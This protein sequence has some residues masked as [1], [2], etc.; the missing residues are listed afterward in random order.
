MYT[1]SPWSLWCFP[2]S[3]SQVL[4]WSLVLVLSKVPVL[5]WAL[6]CTAPVPLSDMPLIL[7]PARSVGRWGLAAESLSGNWNTEGSCLTQGYI[8]SPG[9]EEWRESLYPV[10][11][12]RGPH[13]GLT[14][15]FNLGLLQ[16]VIPVPEVPTGSAEASAAT[17][18]HF[19]F[20]LWAIISL[21]SLLTGVR[22]WTWEHY[23]ELVSQGTWPQN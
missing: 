21:P 15:C 3:T 11:D 4:S 7:P 16:R 12:W 5:Q 20:S 9:L 22:C 14:P 10:T 13:K 8:P 23:S 6:W 2:V 17:A 18:E 1:F 19:S